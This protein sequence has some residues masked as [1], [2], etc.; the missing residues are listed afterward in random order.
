MLHC[1][2]DRWGHIRQ[3]NRIS[4]CDFKIDTEHA[5]AKN[6]PVLQVPEPSYFYIIALHWNHSCCTKLW[7][8]QHDQLEDINTMLGWLD[9]SQSKHWKL[10]WDEN[11]HRQAWHTALS[12]VVMF[13]YMWFRYSFTWVAVLTVKAGLTETWLFIQIYSV[14]ERSGRCKVMFDRQYV[15]GSHTDLYFATIIWHTKLF[16]WSW[17]TVNVGWNTDLPGRHHLWGH[18]SQ[19][20]AYHT[21]PAGLCTASPA[22]P[23]CQPEPWTSCAASQNRPAP[24]AAWSTEEEGGRYYMLWSDQQ[25]GHMCQNFVIIINEP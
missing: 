25:S 20:A 6:E 13:C 15:K 1:V 16:V 4:D 12:H 23:C 10:H 3:W 8:V 17:W 24:M 19:G 22:R 2:Q 11:R 14:L 9:W 18:P 21:A 5:N 7:S